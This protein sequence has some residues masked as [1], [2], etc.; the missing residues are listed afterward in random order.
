MVNLC[1]TMVIPTYLIRIK[2]NITI[3][4]I[5]MCTRYLIELSPELRP[6]IEEARRS[7]LTKKMTDKLGQALIAE[8]EVRP[9]DMV[10]VIAPDK[11][12]LRKVFPMVWGFRFPGIN[13]PIVNARVETAGQKPA[14]RDSWQRR[15]CIIPA[16]YYFEWEHIQKGNRIVP[17]D[18]YAIQTPGRQVTWLAG[19]YRIE[20][21]DTGFQYPVFTVLTRKPSPMLQKIHNRMPVVLPDEAV[22]SWICPNLSTRDVE[23]IASLSITDMIAEKI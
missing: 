12:G 6:I 19:L 13:H 7:H 16:S 21:L 3:W 22:L 11:N 17:G 23:E 8:G 2:G 18:K 5:M 1:Y 20:S 14:F 15:R 10:P 9:T 4:R